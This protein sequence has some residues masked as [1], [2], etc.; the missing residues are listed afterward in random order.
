M[1]DTFPSGYVDQKTG[2]IESFQSTFSKLT[3]EAVPNLGHWALQAGKL[4]LIAPFVGGMAVALPVAAGLYFGG[5]YVMQKSLNA[6]HDREERQGGPFVEY[7][8]TQD[9]DRA[10]FRK[11][12]GK[13][14]PGF[15]DDLLRMVKMTELSEVPKV[16]VMM[17]G[18]GT[19]DFI[20][21]ASTRPDG[22]SPVVT[23][24]RGA[25]STLDPVEMRAV[26]GHE[27]T[28]V[29]LGHIQSGTEWLSRGTLS[30][31]LNTALIGG[32]LLVGAPILPVL[33]FVGITNL[34]GKCLKSVQSRRHEEM[35][36]KGA[37][38]ITGETKAL[39]SALKKIHKGLLHRHQQETDYKYLRK[40]E[41]PPKVEEAG[42]IQQFLFGTHPSNARRENLLR[43]FEE[44]HKSYCEK[45][46]AEFRTVFNAAAAPAAKPEKVIVLRPKAATPPKYKAA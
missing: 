39:A 1:A 43:E 26:V 45:K 46:R 5:R 18:Q 36:D 19:E 28:H 32:A 10:M 29:K 35:C 33:A 31:V 37:A 22:T 12:H 2:R 27:L 42:G 6:L 7:D 13:S 25:M 23:L 17:P 40:G 14:H 30:M 16:R 41:V 44:N 21:S 20:C 8:F 3:D 34:V 15:V 38:L 24:G 11:I 4:A 9:D